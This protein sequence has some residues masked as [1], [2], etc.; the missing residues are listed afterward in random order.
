MQ[1]LFFEKNKIRQKSLDGA[2]NK[3]EQTHIK[4]Q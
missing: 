2:R 4:N 1:S 3:E